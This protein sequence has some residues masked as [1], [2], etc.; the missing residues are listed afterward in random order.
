MPQAL[1]Q[2]NRDQARRTLLVH[3][4]VHGLGSPGNRA[5]LGGLSENVRFR[6]GLSA[7]PEREYDQEG[8]VFIES[9][10]GPV[11][12]TFDLKEAIERRIL[13]P[14]NYFPLSFELTDADRKRI[15]SLFADAQP[16]KLPGSR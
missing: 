10:I 6:L 3:D 4:E 15:A 5:R 14:F 16:A 8:N 9:H 7:T 12:M 11:L 2:L 13:A 1:R